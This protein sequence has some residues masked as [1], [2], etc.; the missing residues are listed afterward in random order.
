MNDPRTADPTDRRE[1]KRLLER[2]GI[3]PS[4]RLGQN[5]LVD[6]GAIETIAKLVE[7]SHPET[8]VEIGAGL[9]VLTRLLAG[10]AKRV[11]A[12]E[13]DGR[14]VEELRRRL[15]D[16]DTVEIRHQDFLKFDF[17][18]I[19]A[20]GRT[21]VVGSIPYRITAPIIRH[22]VR[23]R[24]FIERAILI[25]QREVAE[26]ILRSPGPGGTSLGVLVQ[27]Y[28]EPTFVTNLK[29]ASFFP[30]PQVD[31]TVWTVSFTDRPRFT[32]DP[33]SFFTLV[34]TI[35]GKRRKMLRSALRS[36]LPPEGVD[37]LLKEADIDGNLRGEG[38]DL[39]SLDR[40]ASA[41]AAVRR[42]GSSGEAG[43]SLDRD[44]DR[45]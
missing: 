39:P 12:I 22:L 38:L 43:S 29:P 5:F 32:A 28:A 36:L 31:S 2:T 14:L 26:K 6:R 27:A 15:A 24:D 7:G 3:R 30:P 9:G 37:L 13:I 20:G 10:S 16:L 8:I 44:P 11:I 17:S 45:G 1:V 21:L 18:P 40:L 25:T 33:D 34:K 35:Y 23:N 19:G 4:K 42:R 41:F